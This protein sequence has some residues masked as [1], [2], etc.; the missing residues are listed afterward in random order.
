VLPERDADDTDESDFHGSIFP[1]LCGPFE[2]NLV[3]G[4][5]L[6]RG[7]NRP[8]LLRRVLSGERCSRHENSWESALPGKQALT[9][10]A[11]STHELH[12]YSSQIALFQWVT[13]KPGEYL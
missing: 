5:S 3:A 13:L 2:F 10:L 4:G 8:D 7:R 12:G 1:E 11:W 6:Q 9:A